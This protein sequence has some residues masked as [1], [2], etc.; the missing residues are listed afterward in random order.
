MDST[1]FCTNCGKS[2]PTSSD[3]CPYCGAQ[4]SNQGTQQQN[5]QANNV[6]QNAN[7]S[8]GAGYASKVPNEKSNNQ[9]TGSYQQT[10]QNQFHSNNQNAQQQTQYG[11]NN[12]NNQQQANYGYN[13]Q[14]TQQQ[15]Q[16]GY[17]NQNAQMS[18]R[19]VPYNETGRPGLIESTRLAITDSVKANKRMGRAD[20]WWAFLG[21]FLISLI[22]GFITGF[23][24][25]AFGTGGLYPLLQIIQTGLSIFL[26]IVAITAGIRRLHDTNKSGWYYALNLVPIVGNIIA[27]VLM[28]Q[29]SDNFN[30][31]WTNVN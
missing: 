22:V 8:F 3:F 2:I 23:W 15:E 19:N 17:N 30:N 14:N 25:G 12:Q 7:N 1:R 4:Q 16:Y 27:I 24:G 9:S 26:G 20:Y 11:Y 5:T 10:E 28:C 31:R 6:N 29:P 18:G 21:Q 13:N